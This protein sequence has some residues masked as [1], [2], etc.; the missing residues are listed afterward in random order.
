MRSG[1]RRVAA[2]I[3]K[4]VD[5]LDFAT[6]RSETCP[7]I[8]DRNDIATIGLRLALPLTIDPYKENR[9]TGAFIVIDRDGNA[10]V[11]AGVFA[12]VPQSCAPSNVT[13]CPA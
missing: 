6:M 7:A 3:T 12:R 13:N 5:C 1:N 9:A 11:A 10:T 2:R 4:F 8:L